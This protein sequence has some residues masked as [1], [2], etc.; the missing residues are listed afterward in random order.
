MTNYN[1]SVLPSTPETY[2]HPWYAQ[3]SK[4][5]NT[6]TS[7]SK[8]KPKPKPETI[9][10][11]STN[12]NVVGDFWEHHV[13]VEAMRR[14]AEVFKNVGCTGTIDMVLRINGQFV[15]IDVKLDRWDKRGYWQSNA[16]AA[17]DAYHVRVCPEDGSI[18]WL[19]KRGSRSGFQCPEGLETFWQ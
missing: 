9:G 8:S 6:T 1:S 10:P 4:P 14:G 2:Q 18:T 13:I 7:E 19:L 3:L 11:K 17:P 5:E 12:P 16:V 15:P